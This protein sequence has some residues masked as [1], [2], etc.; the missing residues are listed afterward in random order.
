MPRTIQRL[1]ASQLGALLAPLL[2]FT[3]SAEEIAHQMIAPLY[4]DRPGEGW[5]LKRHMAQIVCGLRAVG[6]RPSLANLLRHMC[7]EELL[8]LSYD[9][10]RE[11]GVS[12]RS[13][14]A[15]LPE[16]ASPV[17][18]QTREALRMRI[19]AHVK[20]ALAGRLKRP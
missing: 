8:D 9:L 3:G 4:F 5:L 19:G 11:A 17:L 18:T 7:P 6:K 14:L 13:Y 1:I 2:I 16:S 10:D 12:L 15:D 20:S